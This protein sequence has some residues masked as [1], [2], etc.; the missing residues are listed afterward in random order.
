MLI[1]I[2]YKNVP[3]KCKYCLRISHKI[4]ICWVQQSNEVMVDIDLMMRDVRS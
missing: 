4:V 1:A 2:D 3:I